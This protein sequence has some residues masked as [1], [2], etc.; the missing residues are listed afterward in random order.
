[1]QYL[2]FC[3]YFT[4]HYGLKVQF[5]FAF[6]FAVIFPHYLAYNVVTV[7]SSS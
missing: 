6:L 5:Q 4:Y 3:V 1:M 7:I 2:P